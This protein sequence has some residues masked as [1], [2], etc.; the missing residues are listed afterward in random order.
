MAEYRWFT[1]LT[2]NAGNGSWNVHAHLILG[3]TQKMNRA[4]AQ[5]IIDALVARW[6]SCA[7]RLGHSAAREALHGDLIDHTPARAIR[8]ASKGVMGAHSAADGGGR[9]P[10]DILLSAAVHGDA[11]DAALWAEIECAAVK[12][13]FQGTAGA[14]RGGTKP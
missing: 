7:A 5:T 9:T 13:R 3:T 2:H 10:G 6:V 4:E 14:W 12:R 1:E 11:D 8:Y